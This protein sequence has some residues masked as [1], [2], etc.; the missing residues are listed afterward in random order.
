MPPVRPAALPNAGKYVCTGYYAEGTNIMAFADSQL[1]NSVM[2]VEAYQAFCA[3][4]YS[5]FRVEYSS[6]VCCPRVYYT[7]QHHNS[8]DGAN[9]V[10]PVLLRRFVGGTKCSC[11]RFWVWHVCAGNGAEWRGAETG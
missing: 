7:A 10:G 4:T 1:A 3:P 5:M 6:Q 11:T 9:T 2:T 8:L